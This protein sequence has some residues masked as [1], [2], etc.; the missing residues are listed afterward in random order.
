MRMNIHSGLTAIV[1]I[2]AS[3]ANPVEDVVCTA[4]FRYGLLVYV[5]DSVTG[6]ALASGATL[7]A[8]EADFEDS[9]TH[10]AGRPD[11]DAY[12]LVSAGERAGTYQVTVTKPG[13]APWMRSNVTVTSN[14]C[15]VNRTELTARL[16]PAA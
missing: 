3:C 6:A 9:F 16:Q 7:V 4:D 12:P 13:Y 1:M 15:H 5:Q 8:R 10:P 2:G 14:A 11:L